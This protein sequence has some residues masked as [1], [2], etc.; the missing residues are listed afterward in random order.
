MKIKNSF[1]GNYAFPLVLLVS[2]IIGTVLG[3]HLGKNAVYLKPLGDIFLNLLFTLAVPLVFFSISSA[4]ATMEDAKRL[5]R[6]MAWMFVVF[7]FI[8][9][10]SSA[11]MITV[12]KIFPPA[13]AISLGIT[14]HLDP[15]KI[16]IHEQIIKAFTVT[17]FGELL[18]KKNMLALIVIALLMGIGAASGG[19]KAKP[20][21]RA[22]AAGNAV[23][24]KVISY[25]ML[26]APIGLGAYFGY[27]AGTIGH[28]LMGTYF[29]VMAIYYPVAII[30]FICGSTCYS[31]FA[32]GAAGIKAF[33][34]NIIPT[35]L[36]AWGTGSSVATIPVNLKAAENVGVPED[37]REIV[38]PIGATVH[39]DGSCLAAVLKISV[40]FGIFGVPWND[41][42]A[43]ISVGAVAIL[44]GMVISGIP[45]GGMLGEILILSLF[46]FPMEALPIISMIGTLVDPP[47]TMVNATGGNAASMI[48]SRMVVGKKWMSGR[49][50]REQ[51]A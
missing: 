36:T 7:L 13:T 29:K 23:M 11:L 6:I 24:G 20:F 12:V 33:W 42:A 51:H 48:V 17:D 34:G 18:S 1:W 5:G 3:A 8:G 25:I 50:G 40:L 49:K 45:S 30:Y 28:E 9:V 26:Y 44:S 15:E 35:A 31:Y 4:V 10:I 38:I 2:I 47:A 39:M 19:E 46:G 41:P 16:K 37:I 22:L 14:D 43:V 21:V 32:G 27:I